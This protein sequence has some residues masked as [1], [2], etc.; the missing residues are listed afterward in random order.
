MKSGTIL[1]IKCKRCFLDSEQYPV[2]APLAGGR[3]LQ[4]RFRKR[5]A[6]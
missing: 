1:R 6:L 2:T 3:A 4:P 5:P